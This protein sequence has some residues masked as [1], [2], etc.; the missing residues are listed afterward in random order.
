MKIDGVVGVHSIHVWSL[1][2]GSHALT[3]HVVT[4]EGKDPDEVLRAAHGVIP[5]GLNVDHVTVQ[6]ES[7]NGLEVPDCP[8]G[9]GVRC[10]F[11]EDHDH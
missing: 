10:Q 9:C 3:A 11:E 7:C 2:P 1:T 8:L 4:K 6:V 5:E